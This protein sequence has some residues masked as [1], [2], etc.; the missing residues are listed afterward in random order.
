LHQKLFM[1]NVRSAPVMVMK[2]TDGV[3]EIHGPAGLLRSGTAT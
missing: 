1:A 2:V 3:L